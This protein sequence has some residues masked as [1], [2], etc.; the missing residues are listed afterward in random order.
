MIG[1]MSF[2]YRLWGRLRGPASAAWHSSVNRKYL[3]YGQG[4]AAEDAIFEV[5]LVGEGAA[6][7]GG[8]AIAAVADLHK[9]YEMVGH[10]IVLAAA[11]RWR[12]PTRLLCLALDMYRG[13][14]WLALGAAVTDAIWTKKALIAGC[15]L[16]MHLLALVCVEPAD[17]FLRRA[18]PSLRGYHI[19]VGDL[20]SVYATAESHGDAQERAIVVAD[21]VRGTSSLVEILLEM[22]QLPTATE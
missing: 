18:P 2:V 14:R 1:I 22:A 16:A 10:Q 6:R 11:E 20:V 13:G 3:A 8:L 19:Y 17:E 21:G 4:K 5:A 15:G 9:G 12:Y 7:K